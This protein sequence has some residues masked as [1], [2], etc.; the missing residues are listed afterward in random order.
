[1]RD[2]HRFWT[3]GPA[4]SLAVWGLCGQTVVTTGRLG[5]QVQERSENLSGFMQAGAG[6]LQVW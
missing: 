5:E 6:P 1:M 4:W 2:T 3:S